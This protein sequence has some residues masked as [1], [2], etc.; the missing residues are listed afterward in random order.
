MAQTQIVDRDVFDVVDIAEGLRALANT[1]V[2]FPD[3]RPGLKYPDSTITVDVIADSVESVAA[4]AEHLRERIEITDLAD[5]QR[6]T[7][8]RH[9]CGAV[10][11]EV[12]H[13][14]A[15]E[16][17]LMRPAGVTES[18]ECVEVA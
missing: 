12:I 4:W 1:V 3:E 15:P 5:G 2:L 10:R 13:V 18:F 16:R 17:T 6:V 7:V 9:L 11:F 8:V 14:G